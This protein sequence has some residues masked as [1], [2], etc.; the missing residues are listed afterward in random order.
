MPVLDLEAVQAR[1]CS[2][3]V[4]QVIFYNG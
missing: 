1:L 2:G 3:L 4:V